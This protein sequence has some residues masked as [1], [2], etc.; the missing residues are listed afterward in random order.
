MKNINIKIGVIERAMHNIV[1]DATLAS[2]ATSS[3]LDKFVNVDDLSSDD[4]H[5]TLKA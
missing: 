3:K 2:K 5:L 1:R 4:S